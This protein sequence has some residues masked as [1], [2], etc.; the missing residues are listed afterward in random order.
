MFWVKNGIS[1]KLLAIM[2][3]SSA[4]TMH[5]HMLSILLAIPVH[6]GKTLLISITAQSRR[7]MHYLSASYMGWVHTA[8]LQHSEIRL[9]KYSSKTWPPPFWSSYSCWLL[10]HA[11]HFFHSRTLGYCCVPGDERGTRADSSQGTRLSPLHTFVLDFFCLQ[12]CPE[13]F[14]VSLICSVSEC[15]EVSG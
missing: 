5:M 13:S 9:S 6:E 2:L 11:L 12:C 14:W 15:S 3:Q 1:Q 7:G 10:S 8:P 4:S